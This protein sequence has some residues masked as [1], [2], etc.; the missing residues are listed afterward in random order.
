[1]L[2][3]LVIFYVGAI[4]ILVGVI[5]WTQIQPGQK[6]HCQPICAVFDVM[7]VP[8][9]AHII[10]FVVLT[11]ALSSDELQSYLATRMVFSLSRGGY[12]PQYWD[13]SRKGHTD[14]C[15]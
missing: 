10:N 14:S 13:E 9:A 11:A 1:M 4:T 3:R 7:H 6:H 5:P 2:L 12:A 8:A 15:R